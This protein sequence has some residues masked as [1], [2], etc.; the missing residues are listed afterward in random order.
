M[1]ITPE[2]LDSFL[3]IDAAQ[4]D[5]LSDHT[6]LLSHAFLAALETTN[7][8]G[9]STGWIPQ[10]LIV[11]DGGQLVGAMPLYLKTHSYGEYVFDWAWA[12][13]YNNMFGNHRAQYYPK[14]L[15]AIPFSPITSC[16]LL[17][18]TPE[19]QNIMVSALEQIMHQHDLSSVHV[20]FPDEA[21]ATILQQA[22]WL[23]RNGVQFRW[24][25]DSFTDFEHFLTTLTH[26]KRKKIHQERKKV[27]AVGLV[28]K[29]ILGKDIREEDLDFFYTC[30]ANT[31][32]EH[33][34][35]PYLT[36][37]FFSEIVANMPQNILLITAEL[38]GKAIASTLSIYNQDTLYG[39]YWGA[40]QFVSGLHFELCYY[41]AQ[42]FCIAQKIQFFEGGAQGE[43]KLARG[44]KARPTCSYHKIANVEF[45]AAVKHFLAREAAGMAEYVTELEERAPF[46]TT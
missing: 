45:S 21:S 40:I 44:F 26:D 39:R 37:D 29:H 10:P 5:A 18:N 6:P 19:I 35:S 12:D 25:N 20:L 17:A 46:K 24:E 41:Q 11:R 43:H 42:E 1:P 3:N 36:R 34:S 33:R 14:L 8:V 30:Y 22:G 15:S 9:K 32:L 31:Y 23:Q 13:A 7:C 4:W 2:I 28:C 16:R 27:K 38:D